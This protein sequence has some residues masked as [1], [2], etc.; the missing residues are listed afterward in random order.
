MG[1]EETEMRNK[2]EEKKIKTMWSPTSHQLVE[3]T[4]PPEVWYD[5]I[6]ARCTWVDSM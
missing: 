1:E 4:V 3:S 5:F 6:I 2:E